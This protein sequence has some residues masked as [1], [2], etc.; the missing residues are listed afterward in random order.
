MRIASSAMTQVPH[1]DLA[2]R[3]AT[4]A[5]HAVRPAVREL[6]ERSPAFLALNANAQRAVAADMVSVAENRAGP[7]DLGSQAHALLQAVN[8]PAFV[9]GLIDGVFDANVDASVKQMQAYSDLLKEIAASINDFV[10]DNM[11]DDAARDYLTQS[12]ADL[13]PPKQDRAETTEPLGWP[14]GRRL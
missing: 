9:A 4:T 1:D 8:F 6:L 13:A 7:A 10:K 2:A 14:F 5:E 11:S 12:Y 3:R